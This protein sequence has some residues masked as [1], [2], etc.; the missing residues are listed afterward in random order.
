MC[1]SNPTEPDPEI[2]AT[3]REDETPFG[4]QT[5]RAQE[6]GTPRNPLETASQASAALRSADSGSQREIEYVRERAATLHEMALGP[7][8]PSV[9]DQLLKVAADFERQ[10]HL[11]LHRR[12]AVPVR[13]LDPYFAP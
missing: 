3:K 13:Q 6:S 4:G 5:M 10:A 7:M 12:D 9:V 2:V 8:P 1:F 11:V